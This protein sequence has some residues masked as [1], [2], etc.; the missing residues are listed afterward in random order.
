MAVCFAVKS[1]MNSF[2][3]YDEA[4]RYG[5]CAFVF[6]TVGIFTSIV[7]AFAYILLFYTRSSNDS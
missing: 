6:A 5:K 2:S 3:N 7:A 1:R 4:A